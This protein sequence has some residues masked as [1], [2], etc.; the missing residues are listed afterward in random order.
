MLE[1]SLFTSYFI[2]FTS[3]K[4]EVVFYDRGIAN[5]SLQ[6]KKSTLM[7]E[8]PTEKFICTWD[9]TTVSPLSREGENEL[10]LDNFT[11]DPLLWSNWLVNNDNFLYGRH[12]KCDRYE[13]RES[14]SIKSVREIISAKDSGA[15]VNSLEAVVDFSHLV[16]A[17]FTLKIGNDMVSFSNQN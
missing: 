16:P 1:T 14:N 7:F 5:Y 13:Q 4:F 11:K 10:N 3:I 17:I 9:D 15:K 12:K 2:F 6:D 8:R